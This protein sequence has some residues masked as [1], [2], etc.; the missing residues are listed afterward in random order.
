VNLSII[1]VSWNTRALLAQCL[2]S[3]YASHPATD[4]EVIVVDNGSTDG[5]A[6]MVRQQFPPVHLIANDTNVGFARANNQ[7]LKVISGEFVL[8]LNPD[9]YLAPGALDHLLC[10]M[11]ECPVAGAA[12]ARLLNPDGSL[13]HSCF[14][15]P[16]LFGELGHLFHLDLFSRYPME[17]W[18]RTEP[19]QVEVI[20][21]ACMI[22]RR[23]ALNQIGMLDER[24]FMYSEEVDLCRRLR[25]ARWAIYWQPRAEVV[26]YG[27]QSTQQVATEMFLQLY[28]AKLLYFRK[29]SG[30]LGAWCYK[31][32]LLAASLA[33][34]VMSPLASLE[35]PPQRQRHLMLAAQYWKLILALPGM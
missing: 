23:Q 3:I 17:H 10:F 33:R 24:Y 8:L 6:G 16:T 1:I 7:A 21:G 13:Q 26:H 22:V 5:S 35:S 14:R 29:H 15:A 9:T 4:F 12:G 31:L 18:S 19:Q 27:G 30:R 28:H 2:T 11:E 20:L 25:H 32:I 34:L